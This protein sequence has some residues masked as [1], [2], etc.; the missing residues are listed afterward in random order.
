MMYVRSRATAVWLLLV[1]ATVCSLSLFEISRLEDAHRYVSV[2]VLV[3]AAVKV[4]FIGLDFMEVRH[5]PLPLR[6]VFEAWLFAITGGL[7]TLYWLQSAAPAMT[8]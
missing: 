5:S 2:A 7:V 3:I 6:I 4:R 8:G 1:L